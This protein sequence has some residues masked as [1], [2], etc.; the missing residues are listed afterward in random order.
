LIESLNASFHISAAAPATSITLD[1]FNKACAT[2]GGSGGL[3][4]YRT[5][6]T[7][8]KIAKCFN[9]VEACKLLAHVVWETKG[10]RQ[11][12][13]EFCTVPGNANICKQKY[14]SGPN[15]VIYYPRGCL[16]VS[17]QEYYRNFSKW[18]FGDGNES[19]LVKNPG[20]VAASILTAWDSAGWFW[21]K[22]VHDHSGT[23]GKTL[24]IIRP[25]DCSNWFER[26]NHYNL[27]RVACGLPEMRNLRPMCEC[28]Q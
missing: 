9:K 14:G 10:L 4:H 13:D 20:M 28:P 8:V 2:R 22:N 18:E 3:D 15:G 5:F 23:F 16:K 1:E 27:V 12:E 25:S 19:R 7:T 11:L 6:L 17:G 24:E 26:C 21:K